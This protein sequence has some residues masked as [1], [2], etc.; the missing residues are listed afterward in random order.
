MAL[1]QPVEI[2]EWWKLS[3]E[4]GKTMKLK[5]NNPVE[6]QA[7]ESFGLSPERRLSRVVGLCNGPSSPHISEDGAI[8]TR[9]GDILRKHC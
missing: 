8:K 7:S 1:D 6:P 2:Q 5:C 9:G 3:E 4:A